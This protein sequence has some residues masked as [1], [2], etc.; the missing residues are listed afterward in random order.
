[1]AHRPVAP[2]VEPC[3]IW[4][5][6]RQEGK[7]RKRETAISEGRLTARLA[8]Y[9]AMHELAAFRLGALDRRVPL[10]VGALGAFLG[11]AS[12][13]PLESREALLVAV[14]LATVWLVRT[15]LAHARAF[16]DAINRI[17]E[18][19]SALNTELGG[20]LLAFQSRHPSRSSDVGGR[21]GSETLR[22]ALTS[23]FVLLAACVWL[24]PRVA[25]WSDPA[26]IT[27]WLYVV[28]VGCWLIA[29]VGALRRYAWSWTER[30]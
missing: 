17:A 6:E 14:P 19:E 12:A 23:S 9:T 4:R 30:R 21:T 27:Y 29:S 22:T 15:T 16:E 28:G 13:L 5:V 1:M 2:V 25:E 24:S 18:I 26:Q 3:Y 11:S 7:T 8:E 10:G 20:D